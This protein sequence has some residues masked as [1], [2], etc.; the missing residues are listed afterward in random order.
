MANKSDLHALSR[1]YGWY[2]YVLEEDDGAFSK[3]GTSARVDCRAIG[4]RGGNPRELFVMASWHFASRDLALRVERLALESCP[5]RIAG[6]DW[7]KGDAF[8]A[9]SAVLS[10]IEGLKAGVAA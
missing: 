10:A 5:G 9:I 4:L 2:V 3:I 1:I 6:R 7:I 8:Q